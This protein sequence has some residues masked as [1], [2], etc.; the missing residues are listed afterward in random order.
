MVLKA[1]FT[2]TR[3]QEIIRHETTASFD[4]TLARPGFR[5]FLHLA[6]YKKNIVIRCERERFGKWLLPSMPGQGFAPMST[7]PSRTTEFAGYG[8][9]VEEMVVLDLQEAFR[10]FIQGGSPIASGWRKVPINFYLASSVTSAFS[11]FW[12]K[13]NK[14]R[15]M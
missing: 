10:G 3:I 12:K 8:S 7:K 14:K 4:R 13:K 1:I 6:R 5:P 11:F 15:E 9:R 2:G